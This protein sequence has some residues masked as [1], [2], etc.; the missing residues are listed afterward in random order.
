MATTTSRAKDRKEKEKDTSRNKGKEKEKE[1]EKEN[2]GARIASH[3]HI[4]L[5]SAGTG[6]PC[7]LVQLTKTKV[8]H[9]MTN[10][11]GMTM[12]YGTIQFGI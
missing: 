12:T 9:G 4:G 8:L 5:Q 3:K 10:L 7:K 1:K 2:H 11:L 6:T